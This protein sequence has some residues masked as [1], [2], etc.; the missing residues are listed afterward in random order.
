DLPGGM[1]VYG[2]PSYKL[3]KDVIDAEI[4][5]M[6]EMGVDIR[7]GVEVGKDISI[8]ELRN[9]GYKAFYIAIG[10]QG[11]RYP[12]VPG[13][14]ALGAETA[15]DFLKKAN[16][17]KLTFSDDTIVIGG[18]NV[19]IDASRVS[20]RSGANKV[21]MFSLETE[22]IMP[23]S[24]D[25]IR[26]AKEDGV[27]IMCGWGPKEVLV[28]DGKTKG[29]VFKRC[30]SVFDSEGKFNPK[31]DEYE[32]ITVLA[33]K[34]I[35]A[36]GQK[37]EWGNL[38]EGEGVEFHRGNYPVGDSLTYQTS[39]SDIFVGGDVF[40]GPK[41]V[42]D[43]IA[44]GHEAA[45]SLHRYV[46]NGHMTIGRNRRKFVSLDK[47]DISVIGYDDAGRQ[48]PVGKE[49]NHSFSDSSGILT[50]EQVQ[51]ETK[52]CLGC[53]VT[54]VDP[55]KCI[56]CGICTTKCKF[57]AIELHRD[58][59]ENTKMVVAEDKF[60][61]IIPYAAKRGVKILFKGSEDNA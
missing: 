58:H 1:L 45:E 2:I 59:P 6:R 38:L 20:R 53:G 61:H 35:F 56:G 30:L 57:D 24:R 46:Q 31:Y 8:E 28:E 36:I 11:G 41:F 4:D 5:I 22:D 33:S 29:V 19:A 54:I 23:A 14:N 50:E 21:T 52:R 37:I 15:I 27:E 18:G 43:A 49:D 51:T 12:G 26:E 42:I 55:N 39:Q 48:E 40:T 7:T 32:T 25:E 60:K 47:D 34:V 9:Q 16:T 3:E 17:G 44:Q 10:C 13:E